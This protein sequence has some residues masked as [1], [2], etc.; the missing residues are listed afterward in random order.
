[1]FAMEV[2]SKTVIKC[3][4][5][6]TLIVVGAS[7]IAPTLR[8]V[9]Q[10]ASFETQR[11]EQ[12]KIMQ[13]RV[14]AAGG[15]AVLRHD[16]KLLI[17]NSSSQYFFWDRWH[18]NS[19]PL[20]AAVTMLQPWKITWDTNEPTVVQIQMFGM[21]RSGLT[22]IPYY[23]LLVVCGDAPPDYTP[24]DAEGPDRAISKVAD[25]IF[26]LYQLRE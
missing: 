6:L 10:G 8:K 19:G 16:C 22:S 3:L 26:E 24:A 2:Q 4:G 14:K 17:T 7:M 23:G 20:T 25:G 21:G 1:M 9:D 18:T 11:K 13:A 5:V 12:Q 15:W